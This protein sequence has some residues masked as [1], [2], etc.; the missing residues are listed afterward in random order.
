MGSSEPCLPPSQNSPSWWVLGGGGSIYIYVIDTIDRQRTWKF[1][2]DMYNNYDGY[3]RWWL[4]YSKK[5][6]TGPTE[7]TPKPWYLIAVAFYLGV[8]WKGP[9]QFLMEILVFWRKV[10]EV[11]IDLILYM[12]ICLHVSKYMNYIW[13]YLYYYTQI[14]CMIEGSLNSKL[15]T[16]WRVEK[17]RWKADEMK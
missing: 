6:P 2:M 16:I 4:N 17:Q 15:P 5:S 10:S 11:L 3:W 13:L 8:R 9:I 12:Y 1:R 14:I 7:R